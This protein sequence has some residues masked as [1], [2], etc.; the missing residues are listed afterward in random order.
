[1]SLSNETFS[2]EFRCLMGRI[3][4]QRSQS[5]ARLDLPVDHSNPLLYPWALGSD[6]KN[7]IAD[8]LSGWNELPQ[9]LSQVRHR[10]S[11]S[12]SCS[13]ASKG[14]S[15][16]DQGSPDSG[17]ELAW[18]DYISRLAWKRLRFPQE[19][20]EIIARERDVWTLLTPEPWA[21]ETWMD[22]FKEEEEDDGYN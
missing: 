22:V 12:S 20:L 9:W 17:V 7:E 5:W 21:V 11:E 4:I 6:E 3:Q 16:S 2:K 18:R 15:T 8:V 14:G 13:L 10:S 19:E 1:M